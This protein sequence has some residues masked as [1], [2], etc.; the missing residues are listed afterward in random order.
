VL[1]YNSQ[2]ILDADGNFGIS[3]ILMANNQPVAFYQTANCNYPET[4]LQALA[5]FFK[6]RASKDFILTTIAG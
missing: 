5:V 4:R 3:P 6:V 1:T 2:W